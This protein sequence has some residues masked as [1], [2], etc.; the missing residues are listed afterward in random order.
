MPPQPVTHHEPPLP[1]NSVLD[2]IGNTPLLPLTFRE[3]DRTI[4]A[5]AEYLN[6]SGSIKDR[7]ARGVI[8]AAEQ[9]GDLKPG[10]SILECT[11]GNT[12]IALAMVGAMKG[13]P[14]HI[15]MTST[16]SIE[17]R[18][19]IEQFGGTVELFDPHD[20]YGTGIRM[21]EERAREDPTI[22][23]PRQFENPF[24]PLDHEEY[25]VPE[26]LRQTDGQVDAFVAGFGT[27]GTITGCGRG[28]AK[29]N[30]HILI[31][32]ME[33]AEC[34]ML[35]GELPCCHLIEGVSG[36]FIPPLMD[37]ARIDRIEKV[38]SQ[39]AMEMT[40]RLSHDFGLLVG[41][42]SGANVVA[43]LRVARELKRELHVVTVLC[44]RA[45][46]YYSTPLFNHL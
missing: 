36:R 11:S 41:T 28:L 45:E 23:L 43:A 5:K 1:S 18:Y 2:L 39:E 8:E 17:R 33:P 16:A 42:S 34:A 6:P 22:F 24:N 27:G 25:T 19:L 20:G 15:L 10:C 32:A 35:S 4:Y 37:H 46:R 29:H 7:L 30:P 26:I 12:G 40:R 31:V 21:A 13:Y 3:F 38:S 14:V 44:D 9:S